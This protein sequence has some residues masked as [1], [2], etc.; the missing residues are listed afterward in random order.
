MRIQG[1]PMQPP[2]C[3]TLGSRSSLQ[4]SPLCSPLPPASYSTLPKDILQCPSPWTNS[5]PFISGVRA[6]RAWASCRPPPNVPQPIP[7][8]PGSMASQ[9]PCW[10]TSSLESREASHYEGCTRS[11]GDNSSP[12]SLQGIPDSPLLPMSLPIGPRS[13]AGGLLGIQGG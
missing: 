7:A 4:G 3:S 6:R 11:F 10:P 8:P 1:G 12:L 9:P 5:I 13:G 2:W